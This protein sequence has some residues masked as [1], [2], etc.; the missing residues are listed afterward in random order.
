MKPE[1]LIHHFPISCP[2]QILP[3][4]GG[5]NNRVYKLEFVDRPPLVLKEYFQDE[6]DVRPR[7][8]SEFSFLKYAWDIGLRVIPEPHS[9]SQS[10]NAALYSFI[11]AGAVNLDRIDEDLVMQ[12]ID[13]FLHLNENKQAAL[14]LPTA[15]EACFSIAEYLEMTEKRILRLQRVSDQDSEFGLKRFLIDELWPRWVDFKESCSSSLSK[16]RGQPL[17]IA[18]RCLSPSDFGFHNALI[19]DR[20]LYFI[21]FEYAGWDDPCKT[22]CDLFC[23]PKIPFP[24]QFFSQVS[25]AI[26][27]CTEDPEDFFKRMEL[28]YP[29]IQIR[30]CCILLNGFT[31]TGRDRRT[32]SHSDE[33]RYLE[34]QLVLA[35]EKLQEITTLR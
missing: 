30:W 11:D 8:S 35:R 17:S 5:A 34:K 3:L 21:D 16:A 27:N 26:A 23:Q 25:E 7:L 15:S 19:Q 22:V 14:H 12:A 20:R 18:N 4:A 31:K 6:K 33:V 1:Q 32:F 2:L 13:F 28:V 29:A 24:K 10:V 9:I